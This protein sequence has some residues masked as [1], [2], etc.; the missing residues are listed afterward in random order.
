MVLFEH[1]VTTTQSTVILPI[2][3]D[4]RFS[5]INWLKMASEAN[6]PLFIA[7]C[8]PLILGTF[9]SPGLQPINN[10]PGKVSLGI[11]WRENRKKGGCFVLVFKV[12]ITFWKLNRHKAWVSFSFSDLHVRSLNIHQLLHLVKEFYHSMHTGTQTL[13]LCWVWKWQHF[14]YVLSPAALSATKLQ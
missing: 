10:P 9:M 13:Y 12:K 14:P 8:V 7:V 6:M 1:K 11:D 4:W 5:L 3:F 2:V